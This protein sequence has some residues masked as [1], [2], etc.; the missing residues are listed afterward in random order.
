M[1]RSYHA[2]TA[3]QKLVTENECFV[4]GL[5]L[6]KFKKQRTK[7]TWYLSSHNHTVFWNG[8]MLKYTCDECGKCFSL[9]G[10]LTIHKRVYTQRESFRCDKC[11]TNGNLT[12]HERVNTGEKPYKCDRCGNCFSGTAP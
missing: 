7:N 4:N 5:Q 8:K 1:K 12:M 10:D 2:L 9:P 3:T 6:P 11:G